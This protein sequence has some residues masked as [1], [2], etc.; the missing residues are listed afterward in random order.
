[1]KS[2]ICRATFF[3]YPIK[4]SQLAKIRIIID[5]L[6]RYT[7]KIF[8]LNYIPESDAAY[9][10]KSLNKIILSRD[11]IANEV[12]I[13]ILA[14]VLA[15]EMGHL[16]DEFITMGSESHFIKSKREYDA[17]EFASKFLAFYGY[18]IEPFI[19]YCTNRPEIINDSHGLHKDRSS[20]L[21]ESYFKALSNPHNLSL[22]ANMQY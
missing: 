2:C 20:H 12:G 9:S 3:H 11:F 1:M 6:I 8:I 18:A 16:C 13:D 22:D 10:I 5:Q 21:R 14:G 4:S 7:G 15:H 19:Y 17:D